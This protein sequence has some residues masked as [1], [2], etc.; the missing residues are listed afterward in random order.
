MRKMLPIRLIAAGAMLG[1]I[2]LAVAIPGAVAGA[3]K[4]PSV[5]SCT[6]LLGNTTDQLQSGCAITSGKPKTSGYAAAIVNGS[7]TG[8]TVYWTSGTN[9]TE[10]FTYTEITSTCP[11]YLD[12]AASLEV[13]EVAT[14]TGGNSK[15]TAGVQPSSNVC[16]Y[17]GSDG[18][19]L[20]VGDGS[21]SL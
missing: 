21:Y 15:L 6:G 3:K 10:T 9:T 20:T 16:I 8:A 4:A 5:V 13:Q 2:G 14:I 1:S 7:D 17:L 11:T 19:T 18:T 12:Q